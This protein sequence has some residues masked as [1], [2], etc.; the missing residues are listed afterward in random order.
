MRVFKVGLLH[1]R[2]AFG[3]DL[4]HRLQQMAPLKD[5]KG[6]E[7]I[8]QAEHIPVHEWDMDYN[9]DH[10]LILD[11]AS[12]YFKIGVPQFMM[13]AFDGCQIV[14]HPLSF[15]WFIER[16]D[17]GFRLAHQMGVAIPTTFVLPVCD[18]PFFKKE[19]FVHHRL[20]QWD[21]ILSKIQFPCILKPSNG[22]GARG[23]YQCSNRRE[24]MDAYRASGSEVMTLQQKVD[25]P[26]PWQLRCLCIGKQ[27]RIVKYIFR[28]G[29]RSE[30]LDEVDFLDPETE[31][32]VL[33]S[34]KIIN[35]LFGYEMNSVEFFLD[36][37]NK[38]WA[39]DFN[40][41]I[42]DGREEALGDHWY[43]EYVQM[44]LEMIID[45]ALN[46]TPGR[47]LPDLEPFAQIGRSEDPLPVRFK[48]ALKIANLYYNS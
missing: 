15:H 14:N 38:P 25:S 22:R 29:D 5:D 10:H 17:V 42:P 31:Q 7:I 43:E 20:F 2:E 8:L 33:D 45:K 9:F 48:K 11:R 36:R 3:K 41:P 39:I 34:T 37:N 18:T 28:E 13:R 21:D 23:V 27:I 46:P 4:L 35:R 30:Y 24:L 16:K 40:N 1:F 12:H 47:W 44:M 6:E 19:D 32:L 26:Y